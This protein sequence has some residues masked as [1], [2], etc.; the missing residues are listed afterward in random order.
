MATPERAKS[1]NETSAVLQHLPTCSEVI[2]T[3]LA[4][5]AAMYR[6]EITMPLAI[7]YREALK[8]LENPKLLHAA[9]MRAMRSST[10]RP[11]PHEILN[12]YA[13]EFENAPKPKQLELPQM[14]EEERMDVEKA[15][16]ELREKLKLPTQAST[17]KRRTELKR[18]A[19]EIVAKYG[20]SG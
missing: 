6:E 16:N 10:W 20:K 8:N 15:F 5:Y 13:V 1:R 9:F 12:A 3:C 7:G 4:V 18:Q 14:S 2:T 11:N 19:R 17:A